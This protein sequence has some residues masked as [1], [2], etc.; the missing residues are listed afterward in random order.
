MTVSMHGKGPGPQHERSAPSAFGADTTAV[1][2]AC[3]LPTPTVCQHPHRQLATAATP[4]SELQVQ[5]RMDSLHCEN[6]WGA[7][8]SRQH[9][10]FRMYATCARQ[11]IRR[12]HPNG[13]EHMRVKYPKVNRRCTHPVSATQQPQHNCSAVQ[14]LHRPVVFIC[15]CRV[16]VTCFTTS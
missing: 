11:R 14:R 12:C 1:P 15:C 5:A 8:E 4:A 3:M 7:D 2:A 6:T 10:A 16:H 13:H 9:W